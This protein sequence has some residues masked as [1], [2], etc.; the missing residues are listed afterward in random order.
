[1]RRITPGSSI[2]AITRVGP[3]HL[4]TRHYK[5]GVV[6]LAWLNG[7][8]DHF[9]MVGGAQ[10]ARDVL[11]Y[12]RVFELADRCGALTDPALAVERM[13]RLLAVSA[14]IEG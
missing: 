11:H 13:Q 8:Q 1:M 2:S 12:A 7:H 3:L 9:S 6:F 5:A 4:G 10:S 14:G